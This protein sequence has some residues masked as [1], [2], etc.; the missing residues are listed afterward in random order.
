[1][2]RDR[3]T[4][5]TAIHWNMRCR[6]M[7]ALLFAYVEHRN[8]PEFT[9]PLQCLNFFHIYTLNTLVL[10]LIRA[11][12][13]D[14]C[15]SSPLY[16]LGSRIIPAY[17]QSLL[18]I[19]FGVSSSPLLS[20]LLSTSPLSRISSLLLNIHQP[21]LSSPCYSLWFLPLFLICSL[22]LLTGVLHKAASRMT[23]LYWD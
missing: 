12:Q 20:P 16:S 5:S 6:T 3:G 4:V 22:S 1:M 7:L 8:M 2:Q 21:P 13:L 11:A 23:W 15:S 10:L 18:S 19:P 14:S 9:N 17:L